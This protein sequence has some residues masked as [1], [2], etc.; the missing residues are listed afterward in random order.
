MADILCTQ[1]SSVRHWDRERPQH[2]NPRSPPRL[3]STRETAGRRAIQET[4]HGVPIYSIENRKCSPSTEGAEGTASNRSTDSPD[5]R[6]HPSDDFRWE[7]LAT[8]LQDGAS[9][10]GQSVSPTTS[11]RSPTSSEQRTLRAT[12]RTSS[13]PSFVHPKTHC[14]NDSAGWPSRMNHRP[15]MSSTVCFFIIGTCRMNSK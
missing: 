14:G 5:R 6:T 2:V 1:R 9:G 13:R 12:S 7:S 4:R 15:S 11:S 3:P 8:Y 10:R